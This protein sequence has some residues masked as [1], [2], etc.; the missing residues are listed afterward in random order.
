MR[1]G[2]VALVG[3]SN[4]GKSTFLNVALGEQLAITSSVPQTT[5]DVL[6]GVAHRQDAQIAFL[7]TPGLHHP[8][9][10]LGRRMNAAALEAARATDCLLVMT[11]TRNLSSRRRE[12]AQEAWV[13]RDDEALLTHLPRFGNAPALLV[14]NKV[15][16][17]KNKSSL[18][19]MIDAYSKRA[20]FQAIVP[21][22]VT[23]GDGVERVLA[24]VAALLPEQEPAYAADTLTDRP[25]RFFIREF[26]REQVLK[27]AAR[28][29][30]HAVAVSIDRVDE[31]AQSLRASATIHVQKV[32]Q[33][34]ILVGRAGSM[35]KSI[36]MG[37]RGR[38]EHLLGKPVHLSLFVRVTPRW[39]DVPR[40]L[41][42]LGYENEG[43][44]D[45]LGLE[46]SLGKALDPRGS[47]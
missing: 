42:E 25:V 35:I 1:F 29:V 38:L 4:V 31:S 20:N 41:S 10:E 40:Q 21:I 46:S 13:H 36:G 26:V 27:L 16:L 24:E 18:I 43:S 19:P 30:P 28:E 5:R 15:D 33:R 12:P 45:T 23:H 39:K 32:G 44:R 37:A 2:T 14:I 9:S 3:C 47:Q 8:K 22:S 34:A 17:V 7:D 6:L 11:D